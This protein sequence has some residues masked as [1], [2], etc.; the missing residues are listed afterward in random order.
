MNFQ[1][2][3]GYIRILKYYMRIFKIFHKNIQN[4]SQKYFITIPVHHGASG[5][6]RL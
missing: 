1:D 3:S 4:I 5:S 6:N 2:Y